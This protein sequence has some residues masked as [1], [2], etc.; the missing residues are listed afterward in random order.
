[1]STATPWIFL[2]GLMRDGRHWGSFPD[3]FR[4]ELPGEDVLCLDLPGNGSLHA[5]RSPAQVPEMA[6]WCREELQRRG[7]YHK[8]YTGATLRE[9]LGLPIP[10]ATN[11]RENAR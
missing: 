6:Q 1:M 7:L 8:D 4:R 5:G 2:R 9:N 11:A 10:H 3:E